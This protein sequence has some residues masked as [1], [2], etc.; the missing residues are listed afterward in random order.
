[1]RTALH[2]AAG[3]VDDQRHALANARNLL[4]DDTVDLDALVVVFNGDGVDAV[5]ADSPVADDVRGLLTRTPEE[6]DAADATSIEVCACGNSLASREIPADALV[7]GVE[8]VSSGV[9]ELT[10]RQGDGHAYLK[11]P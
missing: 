3:D 10:R 1:M 4:A 6:T 8:T 9:G 2:C 11:V 5:R 7:D